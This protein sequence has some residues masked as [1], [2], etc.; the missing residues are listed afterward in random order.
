M[1]VRGLVGFSTA[2]VLAFCLSSSL[3]AQK[4]GSHSSPSRS[5]S[6]P[7][8]S[9]SPSRT[10]SSPRAP[11]PS[12]APRSYSAPKPPSYTPP[13]RTYSSPKSPATPSVGS[14]P[15]PNFKSNYDSG[16]SG[17]QQRQESQRAYQKANPPKY[18]AKDQRIRDL[19]SQLSQERMANREYRKQSVYGSYYG[20]PMPADV[21]HDNFNV[22]F[23]LWLMDRPQYDRDRWVYNHRDE[24]D[25][26]R[27]EELRKKDADL[28]RRL[29]E[30][31]KNGTTKDP[32]YVPSGVDKD[33]MY[34]DDS[35]KT[36]YKETHSSFPWF[37][38]IM[39]IVLVGGSVYY[40][41]F[42]KRW[43]VQ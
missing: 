41:G 3:S 9:P 17:A 22:F 43:K 14:S 34:S 12:P 26:A 35:V 20:R 7:R 37:T 19:G 29:S 11:S 13:S 40:L 18:D 8:P 2:L 10:Y 30:M 36:A 42:V 5:Y 33:L 31:E 16:A 23:W 32:N 38:V 15:R 24:M 6:S 21:Y 1:R 25:Q 28:D 27:L 4:G 39:V